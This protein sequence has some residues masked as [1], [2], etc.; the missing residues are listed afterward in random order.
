MTSLSL[1][2]VN[3]D[4]PNTF[5]YLLASALLG[6]PAIEIIGTGLRPTEWITA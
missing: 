5:A 6:P 1:S 2:L 3:D 4:F